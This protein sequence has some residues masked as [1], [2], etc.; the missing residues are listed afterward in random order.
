[1]KFEINWLVLSTII[2]P[3]LGGII[4]VALDRWLERRPKL[5]SWLV[6]ASAVQMPPLP[7][8]GHATIVHTHS[9]VARNAGRRTANNVRLGHNYLP[10][11]Y[12]VYPPV[13]YNVQTTPGGVSEIV[14]RIRVRLRLPMRLLSQAVSVARTSSSVGTCGSVLGTRMANPR[15]G[16]SLS[17]STVTAHRKNVFSVLYAV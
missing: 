8:G 2:G 1:M 6:H 16:F 4:L 15:R 10:L 11:S 5:I 12:S 17:S 7:T 13:A 9:V 14:T 3:L